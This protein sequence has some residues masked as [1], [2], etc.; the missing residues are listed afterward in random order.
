M[1]GHNSTAGLTQAKLKALQEH[2]SGANSLESS[3]DLIA[4]ARSIIVSVQCAYA[5][6]GE[7]RRA[8]IDNGD[9]NAALDRAVDLLE[10]ASAQLS[11]YEHEHP[12]ARKAIK[13][14]AQSQGICRVLIIGAQETPWH[15]LNN[16][17]WAAEQ[18]LKE[19]S[20]LVRPETEGGL[21]PGAA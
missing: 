21:V 8:Q 19:I 7:Q 5:Q 15:D 18:G 9:K 4:Q 12:Y 20:Y 3:N 16:A 13:V 14:I 11:Q 17:L 6:L 1:T 2:I 10:K